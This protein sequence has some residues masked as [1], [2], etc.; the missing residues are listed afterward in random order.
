MKPTISTD[1]YDLYL[2]DCREILPHLSPVDLLLTDP[3]YGI[4]RAGGM[5]GGGFDGSG[6][7]ARKPRHYDG[8]WDGERP[9]PQTFE[10]F[11]KSARTSI[12]WGGNYF[13]DILPQ[14]NKWL[15]WNK[16]N[17][18]PSYSDGE[19]AWTNLSGNNVKMFTLLNSGIHS[20]DKDG[21]HHPTQKPVALMGWC[22]GFVPDAVTVLDPYMGV[23]STGRACLQM[24]K[25]FIGIERDEHYFQIGAQRLEATS[26][27]F[28]AREFG[29][30]FAEASP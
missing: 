9:E 3:P 22:L 13:A 19:M 21:R 11:L 5:D 15:I 10:M 27:K 18:M 16:R 23:A 12:I 28:T 1:R 7:H 29:G 25:H 2:G 30:L 8:D 26:G 24:G 17:S 14:N 4:N 6:K 20:S